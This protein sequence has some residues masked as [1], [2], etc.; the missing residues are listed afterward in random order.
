MGAIAKAAR[1]AAS[2]LSAHGKMSKTMHT[3]AKLAVE[4]EREVY[5]LHKMTGITQ[6]ELAY[7]VA[8]YWTVGE[9]KRF[10]MRFGRLPEK[11]GTG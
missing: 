8:R 5:E 3:F 7:Y 4:K 11:V 9:L 10:Y 6:E 2:L 1:A